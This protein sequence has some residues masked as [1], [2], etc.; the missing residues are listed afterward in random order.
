[1]PRVTLDEV[2]FHAAMDMLRTN[3]LRTSSGPE[4]HDGRQGPA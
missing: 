1:M 4:P 2:W 3:T